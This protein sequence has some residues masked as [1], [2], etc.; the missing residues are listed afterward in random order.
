MHI[1]IPLFG[2]EISPRF[3]VA[4]KF[5]LARFEEGRIS[6]LSFKEMEE[7]NPLKRANKLFKWKVDQVICNGIDDF[8]SRLLQGSGMQ[9]IPLISGEA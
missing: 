6:N 2:T 7:T 5:M 4:K 9:V 1:A 3:D 8:T